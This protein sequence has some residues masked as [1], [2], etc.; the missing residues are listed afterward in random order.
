MKKLLLFLLLSTI[1][2]VACEDKG[3]P[4]NMDEYTLQDGTKIC[5]PKGRC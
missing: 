4:D 3:C 5:V 2:L 1:T